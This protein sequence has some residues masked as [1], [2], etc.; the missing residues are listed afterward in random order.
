M[1]NS[2]GG[3]LKKLCKYYGYCENNIISKAVLGK[4][5]TPEEIREN[6]LRL[7]KSSPTY[8]K[9]QQEKQEQINLDLSYTI[10]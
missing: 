9:R 10:T 1:R 7:R 6:K 4:E 2:N 8:I 3:D 5:M